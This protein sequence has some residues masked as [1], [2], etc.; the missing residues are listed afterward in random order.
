[1]GSARRYC[2]YDGIWS[3]TQPSCI[4]M[5]IFFFLH[6]GHVMSVKHVINYINVIYSKSNFEI[7]SW[8]LSSQYFI[9][10]LCECYSSINNLQLGFDFSKLPL[11]NSSPFLQIRLTP[12]VETLARLSLE[13]KTTLKATRYEYLATHE[14]KFK[15]IGFEPENLLFT[16]V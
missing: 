9:P 14:M 10:E 12:P 13:I 7:P 11:Q 15:Q 8:R 1:M 5:E 6:I 2:Q 3:G 16:F 4:G